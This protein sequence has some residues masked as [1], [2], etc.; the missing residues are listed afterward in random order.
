MKSNEDIIILFNKYLNFQC[1]NAELDILLQYFEMESHESTLRELVQKE[2]DQFVD[3][4]KQH[5]D[6]EDLL[7]NVDR[8]LFEQIHQHKIKRPFSHY[9][10]AASVL[11]AV[12]IGLYFTQF[13]AI[14]EVPV[15]LVKDIPPGGN[16]ATLKLSDGS[17]IVLDQTNVG[18]I[19][20]S[21]DI[22]ISKTDEGLIEY[23]TDKTNIPASAISYNTITTPKGGQY[24]VI[25]PDG[26][27]VWLN[28][29][30]SLKYPTRFSGS[31]R[32]V[33]LIGEGYFEIAKDAKKPFIVKSQ[34]QEI[35]VLG[36]HFNVNAYQDE[37]TTKTTL[38]EGSVRIDI[39]SSKLSKLLSPNQQALVNNHSIKVLDVKPEEVVAW[40][41]GQFLFKNTDLK[42]ILHQ[43]E[44]WYNVEV[45][46]SNL[47]DNR[48]FGKIERDVNISSV[49]EMLEISS[50]LKFKIV[51]DASG[52]ERRLM[53]KN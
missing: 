25:L 38:L 30:S 32:H 47:P 28:A 29:A 39:A 21:S 51:P 10:I 45:D 46:F 7:Q 35:T 15:T 24:K 22:R 19:S 27:S 52:K 11:I 42:S 34:G 37:G 9:A 13:K 53:L 43:L 1:T 16:H 14:K 6:I 2:L 36:T 5:S 31:S 8:K 41:N 4:Q 40:K 50:N 18:V 20:E 26:S 17:T 23:I 44:R 33:E 12:C 49:L 48:F 3:E